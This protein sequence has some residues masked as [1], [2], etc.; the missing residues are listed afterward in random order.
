MMESLVFQ[1]YDVYHA[2]LAGAKR[3][4][5]IKSHLNK[6][7]VFPVPDGDTGSNMA[8]L[9]QTIINEAKPND[10]LSITLDSIA[11]AA[12]NGSRG[13]SG[14]IFSEYFNGLAEKLKGKAQAKVSEFSDAIAHAIKKAYQAIMNPVEGTILTV[15][16]KAFDHKDHTNFQSF[17]HTSYEQ[18]KLA[19]ADTPNELAILKQSGVVD[20]GAEGFT[21][22]LEGI[23]HY[24]EFGDD[25]FKQTQEVQ[26]E[27]TF[28]DIHDMEVSER[29]C[30]EALISDVKVSPQEMKS[31]F[32]K[33]GSSFIVSGN[34]EKMR[35]HIHT[36]KPDEFFL[37]LRSYGSVLQ[38]KVDDMSRQKQAV[39]IHHPKIAIVTDSIADIP[40]E[41][42][43]HYQIHMIPVYLMV[44]GISY[45][46]QITISTQTFYQMIDEASSFSSSQPDKGS[47][48]RSLDFLSEHYEKI[49]VITVSSK[50]SGTYNQMIQYAQSHPQV[51]VF[52]SLQNSGAQGLVVLEASRLAQEGYEMDE[53]ISRLHDY[54]RRTKIYVSVKTLK[55]MVK[56]GRI[57]KVTGLAAKIMN[58]KPVIALDE[59]GAGIIKKKAFSLSGNVRQIMKLVQSGQIEKY[60]MVHAKAP[61]RCDRLAKKI[62]AL[63]GMKPDYTTEIGPVVAMNAGLGAVAVALTF[64]EVR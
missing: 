15:L 52:D 16:R 20:A 13:N 30:T 36:N 11:G 23:N 60:A 27:E 14:I 10:N 35:I 37:K 61:K 2:F 48:E 63:S 51:H 55:Y 34:Q 58:L 19:L 1:G 33:D 5:L 4:I 29:Y 42:R 31:I 17:F 39:S 44:D 38:Q 46:D 26:I 8:Y 24:L 7:N 3:L 18:A 62:E 54:T 41:M 12:M 32:E 22:F 28:L 25:T 6:I 49:L 47:I 53:M 9:M 59:S 57:S 45:L 64:R 21:A 43:D 56:Q 40:L 50:L